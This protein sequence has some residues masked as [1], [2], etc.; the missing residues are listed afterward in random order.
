MTSHETF[1][2]GTA[3][4]VLACAALGARAQ[5]MTAMEHDIQAGTFQKIGSVLVEHGLHSAGCCCCGPEV[6]ASSR[7][8][9]V[10]V[11]SL[12][13]DRTT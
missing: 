6:A 1:W 3:G 5:S 11:A 8:N 7:D 10:P 2:N 4:V 12:P 13:G 9:V